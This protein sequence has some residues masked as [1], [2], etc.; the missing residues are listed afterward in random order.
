MQENIVKKYGSANIIKCKQDSLHSYS[1]IIKEKNVD[2]RR[3]LNSSFDLSAVGVSPW[4][5]THQII[6]YVWV[7]N[8]STKICIHLFY[9]SDHA[10]RKNQDREENIESS[11]QIG[12]F[13][14][15]PRIYDQKHEPF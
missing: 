1:D 3:I 2:T 15:F 4:K 13:H 7:H 14:T 12:S 8:M 10:A 5:M 11:Y 9:N 6:T